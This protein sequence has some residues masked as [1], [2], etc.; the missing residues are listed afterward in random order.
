MP[1]PCHCSAFLTKIVPFLAILE[2]FSSLFLVAIN[3]LTLGIRR[4]SKILTYTKL[5][6]SSFSHCYSSIICPKGPFWNQKWRYM[7]GLPVPE[8]SKMVQMVPN[9]Q[10]NMC[11][12]IWN[13]LGPIWTLLNHFRQK[14]TFCFKALWP[15]GSLCFWGKQFILVGK[16]PKMFK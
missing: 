4:T 14:L 7:A 15:R 2:P 13:H 11:S 3:M 12:I 5:V 9:D 1:W 10:Y 16:G 6:W 8:L